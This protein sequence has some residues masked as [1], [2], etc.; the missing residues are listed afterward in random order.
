VYVYVY[1]CVCVWFG[2]PYWQ[3]YNLVKHT[4]KA[5]FEVHT[6]VHKSVPWNFEYLTCIDGYI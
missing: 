5:R 6:K 3:R 4:Y 2:V 1:V